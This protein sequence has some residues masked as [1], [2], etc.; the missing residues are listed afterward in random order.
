MVG[1]RSLLLTSGLSLLSRNVQTRQTPPNEKLVDHELFGPPIT[2]S[3][4]LRTT[5]EASKN[6]QRVR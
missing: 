5:V 6:N 3:Y 2:T 1:S 4:T